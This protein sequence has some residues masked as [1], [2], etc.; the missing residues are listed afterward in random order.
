M[1][2]PE[3]VERLLSQQSISDYHPWSTKD[4]HVVDN[5]YRNVCADV[6]HKTTT[7]SYIEW[8]HYGS[9]YASYIDAWFYQPASEFIVNEPLKYGQAHKGLAV[10]LSRL[11]PYFVFM[12]GEKGWHS[13]GGSGYLP[14][15]EMVDYLPSTSV[16]SLANAIQPILEEYGLIRLFRENLGQPLNT[17]QQVPT[18][19]TDGPFTEFDAL[20]H[21]ED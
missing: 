21:L 9:G 1:F 3:Q 5:F 18:I 20:Y 8:D 6:T 19:L 16:T 2:S 10:L 17:T 14:A 7:Q 15:Y 4:E 13:Q 12:E 11:S